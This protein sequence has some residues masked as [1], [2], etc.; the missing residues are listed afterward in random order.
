MGDP[1]IKLGLLVSHSEYARLKQSELKL[2]LRTASKEVTNKSK[3]LMQ[4][5]TEESRFDLRIR[6]WDLRAVIFSKGKNILACAVA[7]IRSRYSR[8]CEGWA[9]AFGKLII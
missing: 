7:K 4:K 1:R 2:G 5:Q 3:T 6:M 9:A 8:W